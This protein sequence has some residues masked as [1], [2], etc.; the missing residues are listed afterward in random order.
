MSQLSRSNIRSPKSKN[1]QE[2]LGLTKSKKST[3]I[4]SNTTSSRTPLPSQIRNNS[5]LSTSNILTTPHASTANQ[6]LP[7]QNQSNQKSQ[8]ELSSHPQR[9]ITQN[10]DLNN[11]ILPVQR[12][13]DT[14]SSSSLIGS[15]EI[16]KTNNQ[17]KSCQRSHAVP[18]EISNLAK[19]KSRLNS[20][21]A[22]ILSRLGWTDNQIPNKTHLYNN[23]DD[24]ISQYT[25]DNQSKITKLNNNTRNYKA[26]SNK[27]R[28]SSFREPEQPYYDEFDGPVDY[29]V[30]PI[31]NF[32]LQGQNLLQSQS[33]YESELN[34]PLNQPQ[35]SQILSPL[36]AQS[37]ISNINS[38]QN[39][40]NQ[41]FYSN[42]LYIEEEPQHHE[43]I[44]IDYSDHPLYFQSYD[45]N[46]L[47]LD[48]PFEDLGAQYCLLNKPLAHIV[49]HYRI[50][51]ALCINRYVT[52]LLEDPHNLLLW[53][54]CLWVYP[55]LLVD[56]FEN[57]TATLAKRLVLLDKDDWTTFDLSI[58]NSRKIEVSSKKKKTAAPST[59][60]LLAQKLARVI[61]LGSVGEYRRSY[62]ALTSSDTIAEIDPDSIEILQAMHPIRP[63]PDDPIFTEV[64]SDDFRNSNPR[65]EI[66]ADDYA[67]VI[68]ESGR[69]R[70]PAINKV[71]YDIHRQL[72]GDRDR[73]AQHDYLRCQ[74]AF[75]TLIVNGD[76]PKEVA[77]FFAGPE[78][79][80]LKKI[81]APRP[82]T[83]GIPDRNIPCKFLLKSK[84]GQE[85]CEKLEGDQK[86]VGVA[87]GCEKISHN[88]AYSFSKDPSKNTLKA[89]FKKAFQKIKE[90]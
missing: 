81:A 51:V 77:L 78:L 80:A 83:L 67:L 44:D 15:R 57:R 56:T 13:S 9:L 90:A 79:I 20:N 41:G 34:I 86:G 27:P 45:L 87:N 29:E 3:L 37:N 28:Y 55:L 19:S 22:D 38:S 59:E 12:Y 49:K 53:K 71:S 72:I 11:K 26:T 1:I 66:T 89:D 73:P 17:E 76:L 50:K 32:H 82:I 85:I 36:S 33:T 31:D 35:N 88:H 62:M 5:L 39:D 4:Q 40:S 84:Q 6:R 7:Y 43:E 14:Q 64:I 24:D 46:T 63:D 69:L 42:D 21:S 10:E 47:V 23:N 48:I 58:F 60:T 65:L 70:A 18:T 61:R 25:S 52:R 75:A 54:K 68:N 2:L 30:D 8:V 16:A 74:A